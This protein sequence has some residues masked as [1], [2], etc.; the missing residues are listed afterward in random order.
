[1]INLKIS[2]QR[3]ATPRVDD[4]E[5]IRDIPEPSDPKKTASIDPKVKRTNVGKT[6]KG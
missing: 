5:Q 3:E 1:M 6:K 4:L 2:V